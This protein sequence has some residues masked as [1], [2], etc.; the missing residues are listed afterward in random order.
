MGKILDCGLG[1][2]GGKKVGCGKF[3]EKWVARIES[4]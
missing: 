4:S 1:K 3:V 2:E